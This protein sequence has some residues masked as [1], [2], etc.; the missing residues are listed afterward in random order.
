MHVSGIGQLP[1]VLFGL[2]AIGLAREPRGFLYEMEMRRRRRRPRRRGRGHADRRRGRQ[3][4]GDRSPWKGPGDDRATAGR[5]L[6]LVGVTVRFGGLTTLKDVAFH[7]DP[8]EIV[9]LIGPNG[10]GKTTLLNVVT[11]LVRPAA[12]EVRIGGTSCRRYSVH[13]RVRLG[14]AR[15]FQRASLFADLTIREHLMLAGEAKH[16]WR[17]ANRADGRCRADAARTRRDAAGG[18]VGARPERLVGSLS[19]GGTRAVELAMSLVV[20]PRVL[21]LDEPLSGLD[22]VERD[23]FAAT[24]RDVR[25]RLGVTVVLV[26][27]DVES[28][29]RLA[30]R[31]VV[32]DFG[33]KLADGPTSEILTNTQV[34]QAYFGSGEL[35]VTNTTTT[36]ATTAKAG[37]FSAATLRLQDVSHCYGALR[38]LRNVSLEVPAGTVCA[39]LGPNGAG[40][41]TLAVGDRRGRAGQRGIGAARRRGR[42]AGAAGTA[43]PVVAWRTCPRAARCSPG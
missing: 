2:G 42:H 10:S 32:L 34:R 41:S 30:D 1:T 39:V 23:A 38:A 5:S 25:E 24:L 36:T 18:S 12:G 6:D 33:V 3:R 37:A 21:L 35:R 8:G 13:R 29:V 15:T 14:L 27:H 9:G 22:P 11:G 20:P 31:L 28:V 19:L 4:L 16:V 43:G 7:A 17:R 26:E 40:K